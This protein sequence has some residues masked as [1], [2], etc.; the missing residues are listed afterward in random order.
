[1]KI[2]WDDHEEIKAE[3]EPLSR[4]FA[5]GRE[6][7]CLKV[8]ADHSGDLGLPPHRHDNEQWVVVTEGSIRFVCEGTE[9]ELDAGDVAYIPA[10]QRHTATVVGKEG[11]VLL[12]FSAPPRLD[13]APGSIVPSAMT[14]D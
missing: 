4:R 8:V 5:Y 13:L 12:E 10:R 14:F 3:G 7:S 9:Y 1:M 11:A 6:M 2:D